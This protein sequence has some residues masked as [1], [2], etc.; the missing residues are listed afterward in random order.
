MKTLA[1]IAVALALGS[2]SGPVLANDWVLVTRGASDA[3]GVDLDTMR[4]EGDRRIFWSVWVKKTTQPATDSVPRFDYQ[5]RR[6]TINCR[7]DM[8]S[9][10]STGF[11]MIGATSPAF[12]GQ[13][14]GREQDIFP[15]TVAQG[16]R[17][18]VCEIGSLTPLKGYG[19]A[20]ADQFARDR[21]SGFFKD[22]ADW[23][24]GTL[25]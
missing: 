8:I 17:D 13:L 2:I 9:T 19:V 18:F 15:N 24:A 16:L 7:T 25:D 5:V 6:D 21:R 10:G 23:L 11:Y 14:S 22:D 4:V 20:T 1:G 3:L 12:S